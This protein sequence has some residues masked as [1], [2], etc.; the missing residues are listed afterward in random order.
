MRIALLGPA[1][2]FR[3]GIAKHTG[4][5]CRALE[6]QGHSFRLFSFLKQFPTW[7]FP[8][9]TQFDISEQADQLETVRIFTPWN[10]LSW[11][12]TAKAVQQ[13]QPEVLLCVWWT[14]FTGA[15]YAVVC[16]MLPKVKKLFLLHNVIPHEGMPLKRFF[17]KLALNK[18]DGYIVQSSQVEDE[19]KEFLPTAAGKWRA[20]V[21]H[22][23]YDFQ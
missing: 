19:L 1:Y 14:P 13:F 15:G 17:T 7:L 4:M 9:V 12:K 5:L 8:G 21:P 20:K 18:A 3:G 11:G 2:P 22:P 23:V 10:P 16:A 6:K